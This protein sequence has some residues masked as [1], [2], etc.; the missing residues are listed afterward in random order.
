M[1]CNICKQTFD[2]SDLIEVVYHEHISFSINQKIKSK[3]II[4]HASEIYPNASK[5][6]CIGVHNYLKGNYDLRN[7]YQESEDFKRGY[8]Q[9]Q[10]E[11]EDNYILKSQNTTNEQIHK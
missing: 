1:I 8:Y 3:K 10:Y 9:A 4:T 2:E 6:F 5:Q 7:M 11:L